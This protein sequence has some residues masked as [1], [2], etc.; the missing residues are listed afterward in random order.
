MELLVLTIDNELGTHEF[1]E[2]NINHEASEARYLEL[3]TER[4]VSRWGSR[5]RVEVAYGAN[6]TSSEADTRDAWDEIVNDVFNECAWVVS[7]A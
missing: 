6:Q 4:A 5:Y 7:N 3:V 1:P 2:A